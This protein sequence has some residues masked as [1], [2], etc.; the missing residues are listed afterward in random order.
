M[1]SGGNQLL[2]AR[3]R[4]RV[5]G[6]KS[7][8]PQRDIPSPSASLPQTPPRGSFDLKPGRK[9]VT[10]HFDQRDLGVRGRHPRERGWK[11]DRIWE[12]PGGGEQTPPPTTQTT[13]TY[14]GIPPTRSKPLP[15]PPLPPLARLRQGPQVSADWRRRLPLSGP[16]LPPAQQTP[17]QRQPQRGRSC[18]WCSPPLLSSQLSQAGSPPRGT[19]PPS[20]SLSPLPPL[21][22]AR[23]TSPSVAPFHHI[24]IGRPRTLGSRPRGWGR[25]DPAG[26]PAP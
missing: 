25:R 9:T 6:E 16:R 14:L 8:P 24:R 15:L 4:K 26:P 10:H 19:F 12:K 5:F 1:L 18:D 3:I 7:T 11:R 23:N 13:A 21:L 20:A 22:Q 2:L 17:Q